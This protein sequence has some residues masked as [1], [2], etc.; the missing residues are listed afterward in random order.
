MEVDVNQMWGIDPIP[1]LPHDEAASRIVMLGCR[2]SGLTELAVRL[3]ARGFETVEIDRVD[4]LHPLVADRTPTT[5]VVYGA[6][7]AF[8]TLERLKRPCGPP[9]SS[10]SSIRRVWASTF[11]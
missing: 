7:K 6:D 9:L 10:Y 5:I 4:E 3:S 8:A 1:A 11:A 2:A